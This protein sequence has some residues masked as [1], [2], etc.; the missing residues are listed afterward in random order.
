MR[1]SVKPEL[2]R[3]ARERANYSIADLTD[4]F[5]KLAA[6][7]NGEIRP[8]LKQLENFA[9][10][11][12]V[13][14]G[15]LFLNKPP[16]EKIPIPDFR[17]VENREIPQPSPD[18]LDTIYLCQQRQN[19]YRDFARS[20]GQRPLKCVR[21]VQVNNSVEKIADKMRQ[22]LGFDLD[23]RRQLPTWEKALL[24]FIEQTERTGVM[25]MVSSIVGANNKR[26]LDVEEF[27]GFALS[28]DFA[29][30][31]FINGSDSKSAQ[32]FTLA[33]ELA[34][35]WPGQ[36]ALTDAG[37]ASQLSQRVEVWCNK[38][39]AEFLVPLK[40]IKRDTSH[41]SDLAKKYKVSP[42]VIIRRLFDAKKLSKT[43]FVKAYDK[44]IERLRE[45]SRGRGGDFYRTIGVRTSKRFMRDLIASTLEGQTSFTEAFRLLGVKKMETFKK[46]SLEMEIM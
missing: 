39:A 16:E 18:L 10:A 30:L 11:T 14:I 19:W 32:M 27:R 41:V 4:H 33:H 13:P 12:F 45:I 5:K 2:L 46:M 36:S 34:H 40:M 42:L 37:L 31:V 43:E 35:I 38:V 25:V 8:T 1:V 17:T 29:P 15:Y 44:E 6:W 3:W 26:K 20:V 22:I 23:T 24:L 28:D 7:E 21:S 9:R